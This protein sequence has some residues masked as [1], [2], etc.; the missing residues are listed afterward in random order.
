MFLLWE[1]VIT[2]NVYIFVGRPHRFQNIF[3]N[4]RR[5]VTYYL[6]ISCRSHIVCGS[7]GEIHRRVRLSKTKSIQSIFLD[8]L[9]ICSH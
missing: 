9:G 7:R 1:K 2:F 8:D 6:M 5:G 3:Q 4:S